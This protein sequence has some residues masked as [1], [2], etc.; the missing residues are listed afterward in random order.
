[1]FTLPIESLRRDLVPLVGGKAASLGELISAG[2]PVPPGF[3]ITSK[4]YRAFIEY[5]SI[6]KL[7]ARLDSRD[8]DPLVIAAE[9]RN[10][11][12]EGE[13]PSEVYRDL[14]EIKDKI[15]DWYVAVRSS[16]TY[17]D[18]PD[19]SFAGIHDTYLG[20]PGHSYVS[21]VK[22]VWASNFED[23]AIAYKLNNNIPPSR[24]LMAV[25]VQRLVNA[26]T[27]GVMFTL[28]PTN[29]DRSVVVVE[30]SWGL[31]EAVVQGE[32]TPD[33]FVISKVTGEVLRRDISCG[34]SIGYFLQGGDVV[35]R[36]LDD[37]ACN[38]SM[39]E[40]EAMRLAEYGARLEKYFGY[41]VDSEWVIDPEGRIY[42]VQAR[43][44]TVWSRRTI[45]SRFKAS[46][47]IIRDIVNFL[48]SNEVR[49]TRE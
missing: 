31:G 29:G 22:R 36:S 38:P 34:K 48:L 12:I 19:F 13:V 8:G 7:I 42:L 1:M 33:R 3:V 10:R 14:K 40:G 47:D 46:G 37:I 5:N 30:G 15:S 4:A 23:R 2:T 11:I 16:A 21:Y 32:V 49:I 45:P 35:K 20:V 6:D 43:P 28:N 27:A 44:E 9:V 17:E 26:R 24:V 18:S 41:P 39:S 25:V